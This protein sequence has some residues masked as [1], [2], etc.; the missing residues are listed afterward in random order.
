M[1]RGRVREKNHRKLCPERWEQWGIFGDSLLQWFLLPASRAHPGQY[2]VSMRVLSAPC[3]WYP[4]ITRRKKQFSPFLM[5]HP[6]NAVPHAVVSP[7]HEVIV[8]ATS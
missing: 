4:D 6:V 1:V 7:D 8:V 3:T 2:Q 5:L